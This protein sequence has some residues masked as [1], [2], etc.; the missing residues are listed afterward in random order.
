LRYLFGTDRGFQA[1]GTATKNREFMKTQGNVFGNHTGRGDGNGRLHSRKHRFFEHTPTKMR[2]GAGW[3]AEVP[4]ERRKTGRNRRPGCQEPRSISDNH[5]ERNTRWGS[6][7]QKA[8]MESS[9][10][11]R[12]SSNRMGRWSTGE[13]LRLIPLQDSPGK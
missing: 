3:S 8:G 10:S 11:R 12:N 9:K 4:R 7:K 5:S 2:T 1:K 13:A 6:D